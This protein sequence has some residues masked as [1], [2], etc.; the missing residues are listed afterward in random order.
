MPEA[1]QQPD[2][3]ECCGNGCS[4]CIFDTHDL[5]MDQY[6]QDL[7]AWRARQPNAPSSQS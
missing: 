7:R 1:P 2:I 4:P 3:D 5:A 6:R